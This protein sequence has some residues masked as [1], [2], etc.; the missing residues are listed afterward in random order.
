ML[1]NEDATTKEEEEND[2]DDDEEP[3]NELLSEKQSKQ[4]SHGG[5]NQDAHASGEDGAEEENNEGREAEVQARAQGVRAAQHKRLHDGAG[6]VAAGL[7]EKI[8]GV[9][10]ASISPPSPSRS[11]T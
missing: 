11:R 7:G 6:R 1:E 8:R 3:N 2:D 9:N 4:L 10:R 5:L